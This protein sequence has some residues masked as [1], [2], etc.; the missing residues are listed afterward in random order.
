MMNHYDYI[1]PFSERLERGAIVI[2]FYPPYSTTGT[3]RYTWC[4]LFLYYRHYHYHSHIRYTIVTHHYS[5][6]SLS[7]NRSSGL[8]WQSWHNTWWWCWEITQPN[9]WLMGLSM[10]RASTPATAHQP[11]D[12]QIW[13]QI[14]LDR[15]MGQ[16]SWQSFSVLGL[17]PNLSQVPMSMFHF[18]VSIKMIWI[19][20]LRQVLTSILPGKPC[21]KIPT[22]SWWL[23]SRGNRH[24]DHFPRK[25]WVSHIF[26]GGFPSMEVQ[27]I[28]DFMGG[29]H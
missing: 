6:S 25:L 11:L 7:Y 21:T 9:T 10:G 16:D 22:R 2:F 27:P 1:S 23:W 14:H 24:V 5:R 13:K 12:L 3:K 19:S 17:A 4:F 20:A 29:F 26:M 8:K 28:A 18:F 15:D